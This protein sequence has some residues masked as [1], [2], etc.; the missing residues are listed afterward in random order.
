M[1]E[2]NS[3][4]AVVQ[5]SVKNEPPKSFGGTSSEDVNAWFFQMEL[6]FH[7]ENQILPVQ[8]RLYAVMNLPAD[9]SIWFRAQIADLNLLGFAKNC[10]AIGL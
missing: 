7:A 3:T 2:E 5:S 9:T 4:P 6:Y 1:Q 10:F 8:H